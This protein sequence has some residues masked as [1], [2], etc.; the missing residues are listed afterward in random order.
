M[1]MSTR[2]K[3]AEA[4]SAHALSFVAAASRRWLTAGLAASLSLVVA[5]CSDTSKGDTKPVGG[6][7]DVQACVSK[8][9]AK[10]KDYSTPPTALPAGFDPLSTAPKAGGTIV[11]IAN[12]KSPSDVEVQA[13]VEAAAEAA[14][15]KASGIGYDGSVEDMQR[16][17]DEAIAQKPT[18]L[19][20]PAGI[21][22]DMI[23][24]QI[25]KAKAAGILVDIGAVTAPAKEIPGYGATAVTPAVM[26]ELGTIAADWAMVDSDCSAKIVTYS[27][28][29]YASIKVSADAFEK[30][31][32]ENCADCTVSYNEVPITQLGTPAVTQ[33]MVSSMQAKPDTDY[34]FLTLGNLNDGLPGALRQASIPDIK[35]FGLVPDDSGIQALGDSSNAMWVTNTPTILGWALVDAAFRALDRNAPV[36]MDV[37]PGLF[38]LTPDNIGGATKAP[39]YPTNYPD[40]FKEVWKVG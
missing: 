31:I 2:N 7:A 38:T 26:G 16:S 18:V 5:A 1:F 11:R 12:T 24:A 22:P 10:L 27:I 33:A 21:E 36:T 35:I 39:T 15:W 30:E 25:A 13:A 4:G 20:A 23:A 9:Q 37:I 8:A 19:I 32:E 40:L 29:G 3:G 14:G 6:D 17:I 28:S 34:V